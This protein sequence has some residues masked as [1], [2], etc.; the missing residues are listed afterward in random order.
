MVDDKFVFL[1]IRV[2]TDKQAQEGYSLEAQESVDRELA[3][4][5]FGPDVKCKVFVD[6]GKSGKNTEKRTDLNRMMREIKAGK[7][8]GVITYKV[9]RLSRSLSDS[10]KLV[11]EIHKSKVRFISVKEGE[12][13]TPHGN[14][15]FN[16]LASVAQY[17]R[18]ELAE[19]VQL[20]M[21]QRAK[22]GLWNGGRVL[23]YKS[24]NKQLVIIPEEAEIVKLIFNKYVKD[25][26]GTKRISNFLNSCG[27]R[28]KTGKPFKV[29]SVSLILGNPVY[30]GYVRY[31][32]VT[33][34]EQDRR[35]GKNPDYIIS[36]GKHE[37]I[38]EEEIWDAA[39]ARQRNLATGIP[40]QYSGTFPLTGLA[41]CPECGSY[42]TSLY[43]SRRKDGTKKRYYVC[44]AYHNNGISVCNPN[45]IP[46]DWLENAVFE[47][48]SNALNSDDIIKELTYRI[49]ELIK[50]SN[51]SKTN[52]ETVLNNQLR[53][54]E[55]EVKTIQNLVAK[56]SK[57]YEEEEAEE[58]ITKLRE[59]I[60]EIK[61]TLNSSQE[62]KSTHAN[63][64]RLVT[65]ELIRSQISDFLELSKK[66]DPLKLRELLQTTI[67][68]IDATKNHLKHVHFSFIVHMPYNEM[69]P[70]DPLHI[71][72]KPFSF[73]LR[74]F[75]FNKNHYLFMI[76]F[77]PPN[78]KRPINLLQKHQPHQLMRERHLGKRQQ[79]IRPL[80]HRISQP[81]RSADHECHLAL[82]VQ[83]QPVQFS[84]QFF[85]R[86]HLP[87]DRQSND[88]LI[89][90]DLC[91][92]AL[93]FLAL[94]LLHFGRAHVLRRFFVVYLHDLQ[95]AIGRETLAVLLDALAQIF[96]L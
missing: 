72:C 5:V 6:E 73:L 10:L 35:K 40:R 3:K 43:G 77:P 67:E 74:A 58:E 64:I 92:D 27:F 42:M 66:L 25:G 56:G 16:I 52:E 1:Y 50:S 78:P 47:R 61:L 93:A 59:K 63:E 39:N 89:L 44:G 65:P 94:Y 48:L 15:Q 84:G 53:E 49:N 76:R 7:A 12:Y 57:V 30:K 14:L 9:S 80:Q 34:W 69:D 71:H 46:A 41:K 70:L 22:E 82:A 19:N 87:L 95:L 45:T 75:Y 23:G 68:K 90:L 85:R 31:N 83:G 62:S 29:D 28:T 32:Q 17:Q 79:R 51:P 96:F 11:E 38:I 26:W 81:Q 55:A 20:G 33:N 86:P 36:K 4:R 13:G 37:P 60:R 8:K 18:E 91:E 54:L 24:E 2:S 88:V 21:T